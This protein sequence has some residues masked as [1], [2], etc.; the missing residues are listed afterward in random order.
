VR[1]ES[2]L[3]AIAHRLARDG[4]CG[5]SLPMDVDPAFGLAII[6]KLPAEDAV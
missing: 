2:E 3:D 4:F 5:H 1:I 6:G